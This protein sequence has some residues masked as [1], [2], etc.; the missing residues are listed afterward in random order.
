M[1]PPY[2]ECVADDL[3]TQFGAT[4]PRPLKLKR[5]ETVI[6]SW[7]AFKSRAHR[8]RVNAKAMKDPRMACLAGVPTPFDHK[9]MLYAGFKEIVRG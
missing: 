9:R 5:G 6:F 2:R 7:I 1:P 8:D 4:F 3:K